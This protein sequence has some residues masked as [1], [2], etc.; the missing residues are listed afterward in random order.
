MGGKVSGTM[1]TKLSGTFDTKLSG[2]FDT[3]FSRIFKI[4]RNFC[5]GEAAGI[6]YYM[7]SINY[8]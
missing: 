2:T 4:F 7:E 3:Q 6:L 5:K 1:A 8:A